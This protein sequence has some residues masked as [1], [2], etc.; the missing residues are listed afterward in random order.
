MM[1]VS[2]THLV[3]PYLEEGLGTEAIAEKLKNKYNRE[4]I[5][6]VYKRQRQ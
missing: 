4:D 6:D 5:E 3:L 1:S 2:Y